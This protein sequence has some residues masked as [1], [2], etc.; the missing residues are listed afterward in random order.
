[1]LQPGQR[2]RLFIPVVKT[3]HAQLAGFSQLLDERVF[4]AAGDTPA[5]PYV[6]QEGFTDEVILRDDDI[7]LT[8]QGQ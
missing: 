6:E 2:I 1:M 3:D 8:Q 5:G 4:D 7:F